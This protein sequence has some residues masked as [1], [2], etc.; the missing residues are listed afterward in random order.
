MFEDLKGTLKDFFN[1]AVRVEWLHGIHGDIVF[2]DASINNMRFFTIGDTYGYIEAGD[3][4]DKHG[5]QVREVVAI[6]CNRGNFTFWYEGYKNKS[7]G[8]Y[9]ILPVGRQRLK[10]QFFKR[11]A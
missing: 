6:T 2:Y 5:N 11:H 8:L 1:Y 7:D 9:D 10:S 4:L 3:L